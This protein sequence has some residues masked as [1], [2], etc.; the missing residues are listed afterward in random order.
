MFSA[1]IDPAAAEWIREASNNEGI[2]QGKLID[3]LVE[4]ASLFE[5]NS[6]SF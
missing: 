5:K 6:N 1:R 4:T 3:W 2:S